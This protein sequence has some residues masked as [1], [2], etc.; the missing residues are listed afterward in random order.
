[1]SS[2]TPIPTFQFRIALAGIDRET[3]AEM[4]DAARRLVVRALRQG[5]AAVSSHD[6]LVSEVVGSLLARLL[7]IRARAPQ[8]WQTLLSLPEARLRAALRKMARNAAMDLDPARAEMRALAQ[9]IGR[10]L[11][12]PLPPA[13]AAPISLRARDRLGRTEVAAAVSWALAQAD[14]P[15]RRPYPLAHYLLARYG[16]TQRTVECAF[17]AGA[18]DPEL[19]F[20]RNEHAARVAEELQLRLDPDEVEALSLHLSGATVDTIAHELGC[21]RT[22]AHC[23]AA[24]AR[25]EAVGVVVELAQEW[26][27]A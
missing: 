27:T 19:Q 25:D 4:L 11:K 5:G 16:G 9:V 1:M 21:R 15:P 7:E 14:A 8:R 20:E 12:A 13:A 24:R 18:P 17:T 6:D 2:T 23:L 10:V 3:P 22:K 26:E